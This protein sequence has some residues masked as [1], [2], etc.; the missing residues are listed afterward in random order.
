MSK[1]MSNAAATDGD[2][3]TLEAIQE[4]LGSVL[5]SRVT[6][7]MAAIKSTQALSRQ[8]A[9]TEEEIERHELLRDKLASE[10]EPLRAAYATL[11]EEVAGL[12]SAVSGLTDR[13]DR[14]GEIRDELT[15]LRAEHEEAGS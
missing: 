15:A 4:Q 11:A 5:E 2:Q 14:L 6:D 3:P 1:A 9:R 13:V 10:L 8:L 12:E 7:L